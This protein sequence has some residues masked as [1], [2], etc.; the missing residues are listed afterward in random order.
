M[1]GADGTSAAAAGVEAD[2]AVVAAGAFQV[3][4]FP[5]AE[6]VQ[7]EEEQAEAGNV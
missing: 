6:E 4:A 3:A 7:G 2:G 5:E 1:D